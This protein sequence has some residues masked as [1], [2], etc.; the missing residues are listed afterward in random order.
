[1][2]KGGGLAQSGEAIEL[3]ALIME[4]EGYLTRDQIMRA[5]AYRR[6]AYTVG[7]E[8]PLGDVAVTLGYCTPTDVRYSQSIEV[9]L[10]VPPGQRRPLG[11]YLL[12]IGALLPSQLLEGLEEQAF[13]GSRLGEILV[14]NGWVTDADIER[15]LAM[16]KA[17]EPAPSA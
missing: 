5:M 2:P 12:E 9:K 7:K 6:E 13:Y 4:R 15:C 10:Q 8:P 3:L 17:S 16:Q 1:M 14:R 11:Y